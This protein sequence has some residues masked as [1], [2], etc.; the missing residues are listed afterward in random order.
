MNA[1]GA[2]LAASIA[3]MGPTDRGLARRTLVWCALTIVVY[4][5]ARAVQL[6]AKNHPL[7]NAALLTAI[8]LFA[9]TRTGVVSWDDYRLA[10]RPLAL[11]LGPTTVAFALP[12][13]RRLPD[14]KRALGPAL[15]AIAAGGL[16]AAGSAIAIA[17]ALGGSPLVV[18]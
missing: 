16:A 18:G 13:Y 2:A 7:L 1:I 4:I 10:T 11:L 3:T 14:L 15:L 12:V 17:R 8:V 9:V 6:R 5:G